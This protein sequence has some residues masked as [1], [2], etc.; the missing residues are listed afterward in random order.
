[1]YAK[2]IESV[3]PS[4]GNIVPYGNCYGGGSPC[5][6]SCTVYGGTPSFGCTIGFAPG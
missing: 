2:V 1:M 4:A 3:D 5:G 6:A